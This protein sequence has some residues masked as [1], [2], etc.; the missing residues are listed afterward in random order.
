MHQ[1]LSVFSFLQIQTEYIKKLV[2]SVCPHPILFMKHAEK[3]SVEGFSAVTPHQTAGTRMLPP[4][5]RGQIDT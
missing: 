2:P 1:Q 4:A 5:N 3:R